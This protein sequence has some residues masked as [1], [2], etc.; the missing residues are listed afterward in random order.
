M[1]FEAKVQTQIREG[2]LDPE[3]KAILQGI[4]HLD[5]K[6]SDLYILKTFC[7]NFEASSYEEAHKKLDSLTHDLLI[8]AVIQDYTL[9]LKELK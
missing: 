3:A 2:V 8:N 7:F 9:D 4:N 6:A 1:I 5:V